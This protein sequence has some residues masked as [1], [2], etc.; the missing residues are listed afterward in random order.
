MFNNQLCSHRLAV[1]APRQRLTP[2]YRLHNL[3][4]GTTTEKTSPVIR[5]GFAGVFEE[6]PSGFR[7]L[8]EEAYSLEQLMDHDRKNSHCHACQVG[9]LQ[10]NRGTQKALGHH[11]RNLGAKPRRITFCRVPT[12]LRAS[13]VTLT[14]F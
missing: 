11:Q 7:N 3:S 13:P 1:G 8:A 14:H 6:Y 2:T 12:G 4:A 9:Q 5:G 10:P